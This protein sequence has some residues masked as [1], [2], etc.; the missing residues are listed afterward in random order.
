MCAVMCRQCVEIY[1]GL[2]SIGVGASGG[3]SQGVGRGDKGSVSE[4]VCQRGCVRGGVS[5]EEEEGEGGEGEEGV[6]VTLEI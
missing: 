6:G 2:E 4:G 1:G 3:T 5:E